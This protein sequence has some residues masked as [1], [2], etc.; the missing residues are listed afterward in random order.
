MARLNRDME[1]AA[2]AELDPA[3]HDHVLAVGFGPGVGIE[4]LVARLGC[5][6]VAGIDPSATMVAQAQ[7]RN[8]GAVESGTAELVRAGAESIP[9][10]DGA[11][12]GVLAVNSMQLWS[13]E[14][15]VREV[16][17]VLAPDGVLVSMT[18][19]WAIEKGKPLTDWMAT[20]VRL[21]EACG[22]SEVNHRTESFRSGRGLVLSATKRRMLEPR[23]V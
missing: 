13:L 23:L 1:G 4:E 14:P 21:L 5:G 12:H 8:V 22:L 20:V 19:V 18:H 2:I 6:R 3:P 17:R 11:F 16:A 7:S 9:F 10:R 15:A